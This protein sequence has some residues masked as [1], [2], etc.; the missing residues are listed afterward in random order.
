MVNVI[1]ATEL[2]RARAI[3]VDVLTARSGVISIVGIYAPVAEGK[4]EFWTQVREMIANQNTT[5]IAGGDFNVHL[6][7]NPNGEAERLVRETLGAVPMMSTLKT[8]YYESV[9][10]YTYFGP[11]VEHKQ[12]STISLRRRT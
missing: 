6:Y 8:A 3:K 9:K 12:S 11:G 10:D 1:Q 5:K 7:T 2:I 4:V